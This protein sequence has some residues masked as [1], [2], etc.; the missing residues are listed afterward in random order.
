MSAAPSAEQQ[1][2]L[3][4]S[5]AR[6]NRHT[7][8]TAAFKVFSELGVDAQMVDVARE[9]GLG[10]GTV[11]RNFASKEALVNALLLDR[12]EG[13]THV[14]TKAAAEPDAWQALIELMNGITVRQLENRVLSQFLGGRIAGSE[15]LQ[16]QRDVVYGVLNKIVIRAKRAGHLRKDVNISD[17]RLIMTSIAQLSASDSKVAQRLVKRHIGILLDGLPRRVRRGLP[18]RLGAHRTATAPRPPLLARAVMA[19][20]TCRSTV[21]ACLS[22]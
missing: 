15:E 20:S 17:I 1:P 11:Y 16:R 4:R 19:D 6:R 3:R 10:V 13:A 9:A 5:D 21:V 18:L 7:I 12:L 8:L 22:T 14:A 2:P